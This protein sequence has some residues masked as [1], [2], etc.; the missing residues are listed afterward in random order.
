MI[1]FLRS[2]WFL[3]GIGIALLAILIWVFGPLLSIGGTTPLGSEISR[4]GVI[5]LSIAVW[6][7]INWLIA[8]RR[9][10]ADAALVEGAAAAD[11]SE[12]RA[13]EE[14]QAIREKLTKAL[15][16]LRKARGTRGYLYEQPWYVIIGPPG[17][18][19]TT[20]LLNAGLQFPLAAE[21]GQGAVAGVGGTRLCDWWFTDNAVLIDTAGR[22]TTQDSDASVDKAGWDGFLDLLKRTRPRNPLNGVIVAIAVSD[23]A[24]APKDERLAHARAIRR[25]VKELNEKLGTKLPVYALL[26]KADLLAGFT[27]FYDD[28]DKERRAQVWGTT[29]PVAEKEAGVLA[30]FAGEFRALV[31][32]LQQ[33][34][35]DRLQAE[36]SP[37][38]R[39]LIAGFPAQVASLEAPL[40]EFLQ[41]AFGGTRLDPAPFLRGVYMASGTQE[42]TPIDR[43][44]ASLARSFGV[45]Q[46]RAP[47]LRPQA[48]R[49]YFLQR[50]VTDVIFGEAM[51]GARNP[52]AATRRRAIAAAVWALSLLGLAGG[53]VA[54]WNAQQT[55]NAQV[56]EATR[57]FA[58]Y[59]AAVQ[60]VP[61]DPVQNGTDLPRIVPLLDQA[62]ALPFGP[63]ATPG[64]TARFGF[65]QSE[66]FRAATQVAY[67]RA[68]DRMLLPRLIAR[69][70]TQ[71]RG[72]LNQPDLLYEGTR[73]Y[74]MLGNKGPMDADLVKAWM[75]YSW[76]A[77]LPG[78]VNAPLRD[79]LK[80]HLAAML[81]GPLPDYPLDGALVQD[82]RVV[83]SRM[84][85]ADRVYARIRSSQAAQAVAAWSPAEA[86]GA[87]GARV[88]TRGSG[89]PLTEGVPGF[90]TVDGF[91]R[92]L[93]PAL[94]GITKQVAEES[95]VLGAR[96]QLDPDSPQLRALEQQV[97]KAY[98]DEYTRVWNGLIADLNVVPFR[99]IG[100]AAQDLYLLSSPGSPMKELLAAI[101]RQTT[102]TQ[103]P[104]DIAKAQAEAQQGQQQGGGNAASRLATV[105]GQAQANQPPPDPPGKEVDDAFKPLR[106]VVGSG[107]GAPID[108][109]LRAMN[110][111]QQ[112]LARLS[113]VQASASPAATGLDPAQVLLTE[114]QRQPDPVNRWIRTIAQQGNA[115]R[116]GGAKAAAAAAFNGPG[117][118]AQLCRALAGRFP[119]ARADAEVPIDDF[120]RLMAPGGALD[121]FFNTQ[122]RPYVDTS[123]RTWRLQAMDGVAPPIT[124][125]DLLQ[126]QRAA[127][128]RDVFFPAGSTTP[129]VRF[130]IVP[131]DLDAGARQVTLD[132][133]GVTVTYAHGPPRPT[134]VTWPGQTGMRN[135]RL[136]FDPPPLGGG[137]VLQAQGPW[138]LFRLFQQ[139][140]VRPAG[141]REVFTVRFAVG[142]RSATFEL[143][144]G[145][146]FNPFALRELSEFRCP[147]LAP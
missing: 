121:T 146:V 5:L 34:L 55:G 39:A 44:T 114:A 81:D 60:M 130:D 123:Q 46:R 70:E 71:L 134:A 100:Q 133:D 140:Q 20:A 106:D 86:A 137:G 102:L 109:L 49:S 28:L 101:A 83:F 22:Y 78:P 110:D 107:A 118:P 21:M 115:M 8:R 64:E 47:S 87:A 54:V 59:E 25:R 53:G 56:G 61:M 15:T 68:L 82:A 29:F 1:A 122:L 45:D 26:T 19:K 66:K 41:E 89:K 94:G 31:D 116:G 129:T 40:G 27:E 80:L 32:R 132:L 120:A 136:V 7:A 119:F 73:V 11:P 90:F 76:Q 125:G 69:L 88:F 111:L 75:G 43:L 113:N 145:S 62:R 58:A 131:Q 38:R 138:A 93:L 112:Q 135:L 23:I 33:R 98:T 105:L 3:S 141:S 139:G 128:I 17:A 50:L 67:R 14:Q 144:A 52:G 147:A 99:T 36:R 79:R 57:A 143:R 12:E 74:L 37:E 51:L 72:A 65:D 103:P 95:W 18:G 126:F 108:L 16:L 63:D 84:P 91:H 13:A 2:L 24:A 9:A 97:I 6:G 142:E 85:L 127:T 96:E 77:D 48:G 10:K 117:G 124:P 104:E 42:G 92:V 35:L 30:G 4:L